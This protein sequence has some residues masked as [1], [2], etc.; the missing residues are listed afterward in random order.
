MPSPII[1]NR[2]KDFQTDE[3]QKSPYNGFLRPPSCN[4]ENGNSMDETILLEDRNLN[5]CPTTKSM[6]VNFGPS[7]TT[8][9]RTTMSSARNNSYSFK[10]VYKVP[11]LRNRLLILA[12]A[13][14]VLGAAFGALTIYFAG[15][16]NGK[17]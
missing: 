2:N 8:T 12:V 3:Q 10:S 15:L 13:F 17:S 11:E 6:V 9:T 7:G 5:N 4:A 16:R 1:E 14:T